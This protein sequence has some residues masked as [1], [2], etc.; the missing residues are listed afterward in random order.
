MAVPI[1]TLSECVQ[2]RRQL[3][4]PSSRRGGRQS[5]CRDRTKSCS[6]GGSKQPPGIAAAAAHAAGRPAPAGPTQVPRP[7][8]ASL[9][10]FSDSSAD[11][12]FLFKRAYIVCCRINNW[13]DLH[14][15]RQLLL[16][17]KDGA[18]AKIANLQPTPDPLPDN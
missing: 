6:K 14:S 5:R 13:D 8:Q 4:F 16:A 9:P 17:L 7:G 15:R 11:G 12:W 2:C 3:G 18:L 1:H 10:T